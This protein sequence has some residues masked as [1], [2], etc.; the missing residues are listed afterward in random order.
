MNTNEY[1]YD[2]AEGEKKGT[3]PPPPFPLP[4]PTQPRVTHCVTVQGYLSRLPEGH[5]RARTALSMRR[6]LILTH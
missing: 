3:T 4:L 5:T 2:K 1:M 6:C